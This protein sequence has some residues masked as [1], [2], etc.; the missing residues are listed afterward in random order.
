MVVDNSNLLHLYAEFHVRQSP[1]T[2]HVFERVERNKV[3]LYYARSVVAVLQS[4][5]NHHVE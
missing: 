1:L 2:M 3:T 4:A 5:S